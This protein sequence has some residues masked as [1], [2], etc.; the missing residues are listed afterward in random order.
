MSLDM[1]IEIESVRVSVT[2][3]DSSTVGTFETV[4]FVQ[5]MHNGYLF[6]PGTQVLQDV[7]AKLAK[8][9]HVHAVLSTFDATAPACPLQCTAVVHCVHVGYV[10]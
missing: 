8:Q 7:P 1:S 9:V 3:T 6:R 5:G 4:Q 10:M 2:S